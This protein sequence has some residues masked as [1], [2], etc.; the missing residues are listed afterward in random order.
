MERRRNVDVRQLE[1]VLREQ[2]GELSIK[3]G[4]PL[5]HRAEEALIDLRSPQA[6]AVTGVRRSGKSTLCFLALEKIGEK[7]AYANFD[8]ERLSGLD[9][10]A[11]DD[12][13]GV[14]YKIYGDFDYIY[15]DEIQNVEGWHLFVNRLLRR[16]VHVVLTGSNAHLLSSDFATHLSGRSKEIELLPF[17][18]GEYCQLHSIDRTTLTT[19]AIAF[20]RAA[21]DNYMR[22]GGFPEMAQMSDPRQYVG[23]L[24][25]NIVR[26]DIEQR[27]R[28]SHKATFEALASHL[29]NVAP[30]I[31]D[32]SGFASTFK[33]QSEHTVRNYIGHLCD[34]YLLVKLRKYSAKS[35][36]RMVGEKLYPIDVALMDSRPDAMA[37]P[38]LGWRLEVIVF[39]HLRKQCRKFGLDTY[40]VAERS[41]EC[42]FLVCRGAIALLAVQVSYD[43]SDAK[44]F[45]RELRGL[46]MAAEKTRC[47]RLLLLTDH[48]RG[49]L[50]TERRKVSIRPAYEWLL[51]EWRDGNPPA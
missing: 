46:Q 30:T 34:A 39:L 26:R 29:L 42:D 44:T 50:E 22:C 21:F 37:G 8:D 15:L 38:N 12:V 24:V 10:S 48:E 41:G 25:D 35:R 43:I 9:A 7:Y 23:G 51:E 18:F 20:R 16:H 17:S 14:L 11:L 19:K 45:R 27:H 13:L 4:E 28:M 31:V 36:V 1:I 6:Q 2:Q 33:L 49:D 3:R 5:C 40:Y 32:T 47:E